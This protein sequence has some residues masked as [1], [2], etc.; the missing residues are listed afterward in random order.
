VLHINSEGGSVFDGVT[1]YNALKQHPAAIEVRV[2]GMAASIASVIAMAGDEIIMSKG[3]MMMIHG[4]AQSLCGKYN[5]EAMKRQAEMLDQV[6]SSISTI[7][8]A[9]S[10][11]SAE[12]MT[13]LMST[14][15]YLSADEAVS[16]GFADKVGNEQKIAASLTPDQVNLA[17]VTATY[18]HR[19]A[20]AEGERKVPAKPVNSKGATADMIIDLCA[21]AKMPQ[22]AGGMIKDRLTEVAAKTKLAM[23]GD[24]QNR[25]TAGGLDPQVFM[26]DADNIPELVGKIIVAVKAGSTPQVNSSISPDAGIPQKKA[27]STK[28]IYAKR[29]Q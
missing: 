26:A 14:D 10:G 13:A 29:N 16:K 1:I 5:S 20:L 28:E 17:H 9:R 7:Y 25:I 3:A 27:L 18:E 12:E 21:E 22:M 19:L 24:L 2:E 23:Y 6:A 11:N 8:E 4:P 15:T